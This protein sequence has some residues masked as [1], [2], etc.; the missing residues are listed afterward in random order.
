MVSISSDGPKYIEVDRE[1]HLPARF[2]GEVVGGAG[3][4]ASGGHELSRVVLFPHA[5]PLHR[6]EIQLIKLRRSL[7]VDQE[8]PASFFGAGLQLA[9]W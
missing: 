2:D 4:L 6:T 5:P 3:D 8:R 1:A 9:K 7:R